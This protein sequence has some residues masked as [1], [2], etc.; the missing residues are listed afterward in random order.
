MKTCWH[1]AVLECPPVMWETPSCYFRK[2]LKESPPPSAPQNTQ[3]SL[4]CEGREGGVETGR[5]YHLQRLLLIGRRQGAGLKRPQTQTTLDAPN[6]SLTG[7]NL[8]IRDGEA[9]WKIQWAQGPEP[10]FSLI[11]RKA[12]GLRNQ[13]TNQSGLW[14][15][16]GT[17]LLS[18]V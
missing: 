1:Q 2:F 11:T 14:V 15:S 5:S 18:A 6:N 12:Q 9:A 7:F 10:T 3:F 8:K 13:V 4:R 17:G 16:F